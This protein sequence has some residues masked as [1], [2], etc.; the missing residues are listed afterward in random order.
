M[1]EYRNLL[2]ELGIPQDKINKKI[3]DT[4]ETMFY[5]SEDE[6]I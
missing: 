2:A 5:G 1:K 3:S 6:R 4:F